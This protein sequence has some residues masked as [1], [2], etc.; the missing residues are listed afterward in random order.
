MDY[1]LY[2]SSI[3]DQVET[4]GS[5]DAPLW[6]DEEIDD[7][8]FGE[9]RPNDDRA[10]KMTEAA[11]Y[12]QTGMRV[13]L[14]PQGAA[15]A[16]LVKA[17]QSVNQEHNTVTVELSDYAAR[18][19]KEDDD[20]IAIV[21]K[22]TAEDPNVAVRSIDRA[23]K[24]KAAS[25]LDLITLNKNENPVEIC[26]L[27]Q[28]TCV[29]ALE[30]MGANVDDLVDY[31]DAT[32]GIDYTRK[33]LDQVALAP[34]ASISDFIA[35]G[36]RPDPAIYA[37]ANFASTA[38]IKERVRV[39]ANELGHLGGF[40]SRSAYIAKFICITTKMLRTTGPV[41][42]FSFHTNP[43][44]LSECSSG[45]LSGTVW[46][47]PD[48]VSRHRHALASSVVHKASYEEFIRCRHAVKEAA[49]V[50]RASAMSVAI[51]LMEESGGS[52]RWKFENIIGFEEVFD[53]VTF[54]THSIMPKVEDAAPSQITSILFGLVHTAKTPSD[55]TTG[56]EM[57]ASMLALSSC[58]SYAANIASHFGLIL[59]IRGLRTAIQAVNIARA[60]NDISELKGLIEKYGSTRTV[61]GM[62]LTCRHVQHTRMAH[63]LAWDKLEEWSHGARLPN[64]IQPETGYKVGRFR[65]YAK[66]AVDMMRKVNPIRPYTYLGSYHSAMNAQAMAT[67]IFDCSVA[68][69]LDA[70]CAVAAKARAARKG[71]AN[72]SAPN[73]DKIKF[74]VIFSNVRAKWVR[75]YTELANAWTSAC[76]ICAI[77]RV[78]Q[79]TSSKKAAMMCYSGCITEVCV[80]HGI[81]LAFEFYE[82]KFKDLKGVRDKVLETYSRALRS[83][84]DV[85][86]MVVVDSKASMLSSRSALTVAL[87]EKAK[88]VSDFS[89]R[90]PLG[91]EECKSIMRS[92]YSAAG[93]KVARAVREML[94]RDKSLVQK[95]AEILAPAPAPPPAPVPAPVVG[96]SSFSM[97]AVFGDIAPK[98][99][100]EPVP[101]WAE[102]LCSAVDMI[103]WALSE[104]CP[105]I[106]PGVN[107]ICDL[108]IKKWKL[109]DGMRD[110]VVMVTRWCSMM[111]DFTPEMGD[112]FIPQDVQDAFQALGDALTSGQAAADIMA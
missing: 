87:E 4:Y 51:K 95:E 60:M 37:S 104:A 57:I 65:R 7:L 93:P 9:D 112:K 33:L 107:A 80:N 48:E 100:P 103:G 18:L 69:A 39:D 58:C 88:T 26:M 64:A 108:S 8:L 25:S 70:Q 19:F 14:A 55:F 68:K 102:S 56:V 13:D 106:D 81:A 47:I 38:R 77:E 22:L 20:D 96:H 36:G 85:S 111:C 78:K 67:S 98:P 2:S 91:I 16:N 75:F 35:T 61:I 73:G 52:S 45:G 28:I 74:R 10:L 86:K 72:R 110:Q 89:A 40:F 105:R 6:S 79:E 44:H 46:A 92:A 17:G 50:Q 90:G 66:A 41:A 43:A 54:K 101:K 29:Q 30:H 1:E 32:W 5:C 53:P 83:T 31:I 24:K 62:Y 15:V 97:A 3:R 82:I 12:R 27:D 71:K 94:E 23:S 34:V 63:T 84:A 59:S 11:I 21:P 99:P 109:L 49:R 42:T 76:K